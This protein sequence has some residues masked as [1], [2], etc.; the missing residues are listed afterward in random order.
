[1]IACDTPTLLIIA[2]RPCANEINAFVA[3]TNYYNSYKQPPFETLLQK[4]KTANI[5]NIIG[6]KKKDNKMV[7]TASGW[8]ELLTKNRK[9]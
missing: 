5:Q 1:M 7:A 6:I 9:S 8:W 4:W 2:L 3:S